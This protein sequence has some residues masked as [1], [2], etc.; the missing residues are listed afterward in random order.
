MLYF[1]SGASRS[2]KTILAKEFAT[3]KG[4]PY[5]S[6][7]WIVMGFT[8]GIPEYGLHDLLMPAEIAERGWNFIKAMCESM[9]WLGEDC[10]IEGEALLPHLFI[11]LR[12]KHPDQIKICFLGFTEVD[13]VQKAQD[14]KTYSTGKNDWM[15]DK[16]DDYILDHVKNMIGH[17]LQIKAACEAHEM[18]YFDTSKEFQ[19]VLKKA[20]QFLLP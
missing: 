14:I 2:G 8:N 20:N 11:E 12:D 3:Q 7:D 5:L 9:L 15:S 18:A 16:E 6:L 17:S 10:V 1:I 13:P 19:L 4:I